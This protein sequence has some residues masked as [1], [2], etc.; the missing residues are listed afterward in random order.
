SGFVA[1]DTL[2]VNGKL[3]LGEN[4]ADLA[5]LLVAYDAYEL[6]LKGRKRPAP[7]EGF[8]PEQ[9]F[10]LAFAQGWRETTRPERQRTLVLTDPHSPEK[11]RVNGP[12]SNVQEFARAFGCKAGDAM[13]R[14]DSLRATIW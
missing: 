12:V 2:H 5:G 9:R 14:P 8:S 13:V 10:F 1:V 7:I 3:T 11:W 6:S 4:L